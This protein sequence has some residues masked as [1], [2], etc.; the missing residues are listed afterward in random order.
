MRLLRALLFLFCFTGLVAQSTSSPTRTIAGIVVDG[1]TGSPLPRA[2]VEIPGE[3]AALTGP[4][5]KFSFSLPAG[6]VQIMATK[7]GYLMPHE[8]PREW[9]YLRFSMEEPQMPFSSTEMGPQNDKV[10][11]TL[12]PEAVLFGQAIGNDGEPL[13]RAGVEAFTFTSRQGHRIL[14]SGGTA[15]TDED[16]NFRMAGLAAGEYYVRVKPQKISGQLAE[17]EMPGSR[18][19]Y[20]SIVYYPDA[21]SFSGAMPVKLNSG[22]RLELHFSLKTQAAFKV[23]GRVVANSRWKQLT[24]PLIVEASGEPLFTPD[25][26]DP[27]TGEFEFHAVPSGTYQIESNGTSLED[28]PLRNLQNLVVTRPIT[29]LQILLRLGIDIPVVVRTEFTQLRRQDLC[30]PIRKA[31]SDCSDSF[32]AHVRL[33]PED[34]FHTGFSFRPGFGEEP[35]SLVIR[36]VLPGRYRAVA[37]VSLGGAVYLQSLRSGAADLLR[38]DLVVPED[39]LAPPVEAVLRDDGAALS[40][41]IRAE[42]NVQ[43]ATVVVEREGEARNAERRIVSGN[44]AVAFAGLAPGNYQVF[45]FDS[46][47]DLNYAE[48][49]VLAKYS[50]QAGAITLAPNG[51]SSI[52][53]DLIHAEE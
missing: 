23:S 13:E 47:E 27:T 49:S 4:D 52:T 45:A 12:L 53:V 5:G 25:K 37:S 8:K 29:D 17:V 48:P 22:Q 30:T 10:V 40:V 34:D 36:G 35:G 26:F 24:P 11:L 44:M 20:P 31:V 14:V 50:A 32:L 7:P 15:S 16:G 3:E 28:R 42:K 1:F 38:E 21:A 41:K 43:Q 19:S 18:Q 46:I 51:N 6:T 9:Q 2:L 39:G 33:Q